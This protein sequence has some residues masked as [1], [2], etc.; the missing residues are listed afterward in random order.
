LDIQL[1]THYPVRYP[2][3]KPDNGHLC[4]PL[5]IHVYQLETRPSSP[6]G[7]PIHILIKGFLFYVSEIK[8]LDKFLI[9]CDVVP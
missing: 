7:P 1:Q 9:S 2:T 3:G 4:S 6:P 5:K 8:R